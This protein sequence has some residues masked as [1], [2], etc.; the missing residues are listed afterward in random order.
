M[1]VNQFADMTEKEF[2]EKYIGKGIEKKRSGEIR[3]FTAKEVTEIES[4]MSKKKLEQGLTSYQIVPDVD[5]PDNKNWYAEGIVSRPYNQL[6][7]GS[8]WAFS[9]AATMESLAV[10]SGLDATVQE[11]SV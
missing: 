10:L 11:Y 5:V 2:E 1:E 8:C 6:N 9:A 3:P 7:C 4:K